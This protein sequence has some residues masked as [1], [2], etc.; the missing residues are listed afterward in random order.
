MDCSKCAI[1]WI[2]PDY[3]YD[4]DWPIIKGLN[5]YFEIHWFLIRGRGSLREIPNDSNID[6]IIQLKYRNRDVRIISSYISLLRRI[7]L[8]KP[9]IIYN[10]YLG[11]PFFVPLLFSFYN[12]KRIIFEGHEINPYV[13]ANHSMITVFSSRYNLRN[14][15]LVQ[16]FSKHSIGEF[17]KLYPGR[18]C[19]YIPMV[20]K[21]YGIPSEIIEHNGKKV[22][23]FF[24]GVRSTKRFDVLLDAFL[25][26]D[27]IY[28]KKAELW[29]YGNS[30]GP[31]KELYLNKAKGYDNI[32][33]KLD[34]VPDNQVA[35]LFCSASFLVQPYQQITQSGPM[36]IAYNY[37]LPIIATNIN[38]FKER[39]EDGVNGYLFEKNDV[40][41]LKRVL[42]F[43]INQSEEDYNRIKE[44]MKAFVDKEYSQFAIIQKYKEMLV[45]FINS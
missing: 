22:F 36:M 14:V 19:C 37:N 29:V 20:P 45:N 41:D 43:C 33:M 10:G 25:E 18:V 44:N 28:L 24:G 30:S 34:F 4:V 40:K 31:E 27:P 9:A 42:E 32:K 13:S 26:L 5:A 39:I 3:F 12:K 16:V 7:K 8:L 2:T 11:A 35:N 38:G 15:G 1:V 21:D 23:L 17:N 6:E